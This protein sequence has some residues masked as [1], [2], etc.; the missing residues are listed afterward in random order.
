MK[1][2]SSDFLSCRGLVRR[3]GRSTA[4]DGVDLDVSRRE[5]VCL[6]GPS[7]GGKSTLL[8]LIGAMDRPDAGTVT[9]EGRDVS[10]MSDRDASRFRRVEL[11]FVF[12]LFHLIPTVNVLGNVALPARLASRSTQEAR[13]RADELIERVGLS[14][15]RL[16]SP[17][18]LSGG[19]QQR[20]AIARALINDPKLILADEPTGALDR[21][22][23]QA[24]LELLAEV[25]NERGS[26][27]VMATHS[28]E[29]VRFAD[30]VERIVDGRVLDSSSSREASL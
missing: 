14:S 13:D 29:A 4:L 10:R 16:E 20:V 25:V 24:I 12:Q 15:K 3:F 26:S 21:A 1:P 22:T 5:T 28:E 9:L 2:D 23:G 27:L 18:R 8:H 7:G 19:E 30:R 11:G 6:V 17:D